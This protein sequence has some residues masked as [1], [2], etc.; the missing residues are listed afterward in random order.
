MLSELRTIQEKLNNFRDDIKKSVP[1]FDRLLRN[2]DH[3]E[4]IISFHRFLCP[5]RDNGRILG[6]KS[7]SI[8]IA[9]PSKVSFIQE[10]EMVTASLGTYAIQEECSVE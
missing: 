4:P 10:R 3:S 6:S 7:T 9:S 8:F 1:Y 2:H 5:E